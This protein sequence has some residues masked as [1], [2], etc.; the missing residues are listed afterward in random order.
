MSTFN[1]L[2]MPVTSGRIKHPSIERMRAIAESMRAEFHILE[3]DLRYESP[4]K[5]LSTIERLSSDLL[6]LPTAIVFG[7]RA[8]ELMH[9]SPIPVLLVPESPVPRKFNSVLVPMSGEIRT[10]H[11]LTLGIKLASEFAVPL[12]LIYVVDPETVSEECPC[13]LLSFLD[14]AYHEY[15]RML[16]ELIAEASPL[17]SIEEKASIRDFHFCTGEA[18]REIV[19]QMKK[20]HTSLVAIEWHGRLT[21]GHARVLKHILRQAHCLI[22]LV[23]TESHVHFR[24]KVGKDFA[25]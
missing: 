6:V 18:A 24:L 12:D 2:L 19:N 8:Q 15:P 9:K 25:A 1:S 14:D 10:S 23:K 20:R 22:L 3:I 16:E 17:T 4:L 11:A 7:S 21:R 5:M 13:P